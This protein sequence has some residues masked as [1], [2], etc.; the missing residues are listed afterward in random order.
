MGGREGGRGGREREGGREQ[1]KERE[2]GREGGEGKR[3]RERRIEE[4][5]KRGRGGERWK[6]VSSNRSTK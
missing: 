3:G 4:E 6:E 1:S 2:G 5:R